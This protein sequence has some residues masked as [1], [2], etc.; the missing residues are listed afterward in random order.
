MASLVGDAALTTPVGAWP[1]TPEAGPPSTPPWTP[2]SG[3]MMGEGR[4]EAR[5]V[6]KLASDAPEAQ[7]DAGW[8]ARASVVCAVGEGR[9]KAG[10]GGAALGLWL[11]N[12][13]PE[14]ATLVMAKS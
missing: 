7:T 14:A 10:L 6:T 8:L 12:M 5:G 11:A 4:G 13:V 9:A 1:H 2:R 3:D